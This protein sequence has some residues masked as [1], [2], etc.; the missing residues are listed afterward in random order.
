MPLAQTVTFLLGID[1][2][3][4]SVP[5][6]EK[7]KKSKSHL[8]YFCPTSDLTYNLC[9]ILVGI[10]TGVDPK[11]NHENM[12]D[13]SCRVLKDTCLASQCWNREAHRGF[14]RTCFTGIGFGMTLSPT[15]FTV[16]PFPPELVG[17]E[18]S[19]C[20]LFNCTPSYDLRAEEP[21]HF[22]I[23]LKML[24]LMKF[25]VDLKKHFEFYLLCI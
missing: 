12:V 14:S 1:Y 20:F 21:R 10:Q 4:E 15:P 18:L 3:H 25:S 19:C 24:S 16:L 7:K 23:I 2:S 22:Q 8:P 17:P 5:C 6:K 13:S 11:K 9:I